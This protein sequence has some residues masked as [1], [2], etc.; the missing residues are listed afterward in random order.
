[1]I[2]IHNFYFIVY[3]YIFEKHKYICKYDFNWTIILFNVPIIATSIPAAPVQIISTYGCC[4]VTAILL[5]TT[6]ESDS[7]SR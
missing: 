2:E 6:M 7:K 3:C 1:M 5:T 4:W